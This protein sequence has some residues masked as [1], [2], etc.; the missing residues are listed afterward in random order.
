MPNQRVIGLVVLLSAGAA[1]LRSDGGSSISGGSS[2]GSSSSS[3]GRIQSVPADRYASAR[4]YIA[5]EQWA[6]AVSALQATAG[7]ASADWNN[8]MG[9]CSRSS[10]PPDLAAAERSYQAALAINPKHLGTLEY[11]GEMRLQQGNLPGAEQTL[12]VLGRA[13]LSKSREYKELQQAIAMRHG[14]RRS[15]G[16]GGVAA[17]GH[18]RFR[19]KVAYPP[20]SSHVPAEGR[21][22]GRLGEAHLGGDALHVRGTRKGSPPRRPGR[23]QSRYE[24]RTATIRALRTVS[25]AEDPPPGGLWFLAEDPR[26]MAAPDSEPDI[27]KG[28]STGACEPVILGALR[29]PIR[30]SD[31]LGVTSRKNLRPSRLILFLS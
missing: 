26:M 19:R 13:T 6:K 28:A 20:R 4:R 5:A 17:G 9:F 14:Q 21:H 30:A 27:S 24:K 7:P 3:L 16:D 1:I 18:F 2:S 22:E 29:H 31:Y 11:L 12:D 23:A 10:E 25:R 15:Q 8:L